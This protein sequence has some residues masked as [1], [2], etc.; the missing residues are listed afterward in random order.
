[1]DA[2]RVE[3]I[4]DISD[5]RLAPYRNLKDRDLAREHGLFICEGEHLVRRLLRSRFTV[6]S[7]LVAEQR[8]ASLVD[9]VPA[10]VP[11]H[12]GSE[13]MLS[14]ILGYDFHR[15]VM[16]CGVRP[17]GRTVRDLLPATTLVVAPLLYNA[18]NLG[19]IIRTAAALGAGGVLVG[20]R[21]V[22]PYSRRVVRVSMGAVLSLPLVQS[23]NLSADLAHLRRKAG[24]ELIATVL[25]DRA[26]PLAD[27]R[28]AERVAVLLGSEPEGL[29]PAVL[30]MCDRLVT[31][32]MHHGTNS[33]NVA[34]AAGVVL[35]QLTGGAR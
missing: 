35:Y 22:D 12:V 2:A 9:E 26:V 24:F 19:L 5:P 15:G 13:A 28:R 25:D 7:V 10:G 4:Q 20:P 8:V 21:G 27:Y 34:V 32:P 11:V 33:L 6:H 14:D 18:E 31:I 1:M 29:E 17:T 16:A 23:A 30:E 3:H